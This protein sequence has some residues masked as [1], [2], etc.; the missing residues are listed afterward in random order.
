[1]I[2]Q[3]FSSFDKKYNS[4]KRPS[5]TV[6]RSL[7][8]YLKEP[9][10]IMNPVINIERLP[11]D[12]N[13]CIYTYAIIPSFQRFYFVEDWVWNNGLWE[14]HMSEDVLATWK[15]QIGA[16]T[17]YVLRND[18]TTDFNGEITDVTYPATTDYTTRSYI[19]NGPFPT[20]ISVG[21]Y[22]VGIISGNSA[23]A[24]GAVS[25][26]AMDSFQFGVLNS[27][28]LSDNNLI[29]MGLA[30]L[31]PSTGE[32]E[33]TM[34][35]MSLELLKTMYN[36]FQYIVS[37][38]WF[39]FPVSTIPNTQLITTGIKIGWWEYPSISGSLMYAQ[40]ANFAEDLPI[41]DHPQSSRGS[42]LNYSPYTR[43]TLI[44]R[45]GTVAVDGAY[46]NSGFNRIGI[47]YVV[48]LITGQC[49]AGIERLQ[50]HGSGFDSDI[51][52]QREF[53]LGVPIQLAQVGTDYLGTA[54]QS[55]G[56]AGNVMSGAVEGFMTGGVGG[57]V[58]GAISGGASGIYNAINTAMPQMETSGH[59]GSFLAPANQT[60]LI[61]QFFTIV[62]E[63]I[64]HRGRPLCEL[65]RLDTLTGFIL[66][67][68]G[69]IDI[70]CMDNERKS[71][72][73]HLTTGFF[74]E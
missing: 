24:V 19:S 71:I 73:N 20:T 22:V 39:P 55:I 70:S 74:W 62:D 5:G 30:I 21:C 26:Y 72:M 32:L 15:P 44:G 41:T 67:S 7:T 40:T 68:E 35:D 38:M 58:A 16:S 6:D 31:N 4:T 47:E 57:A 69:E 37:C 54:V 25:Y 48:D 13:P 10:S 23:S 36:P 64:E 60:R 66:C 2:I 61:E 34:T 9:C 28:L 56:I 51:I 33:P 3:F 52:T 11:Q 49:K 8:G 46:F 18:S 27:A 45:F 43:R 12:A 17:E 1:M 53:L 63:D 14:V 65:R 29:T 59:N 42:Y 50:Q